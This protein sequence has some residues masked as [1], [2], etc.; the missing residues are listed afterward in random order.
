M[1]LSEVHCSRTSSRAIV[2]WVEGSETQ[3]CISCSH[4]I[5]TMQDAAA[6]PARKSRSLGSPLAKTTHLGSRSQERSIG[7]A[8]KYAARLMDD[9]LTPIPFE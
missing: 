5:P 9:M 7:I 6:H 3:R 1:K 2:G 4:P 8:A